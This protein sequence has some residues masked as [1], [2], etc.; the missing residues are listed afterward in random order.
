MQA[1]TLWFILASILVIFEI[2]TGTFYLLIFGAAA[3]AAAF[4]AFYGYT[5][6]IQLI[7]AAV[8][9]VAGVQ[10]LRSHP[11]T[12]SP[13]TDDLDISQPVEI[14]AW[15]KDGTARVRYRGTEW[16]ARLAEGVTGQPSQ[17]V[18]HAMQGNTL[19]LSPAK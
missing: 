17:C 6:S 8:F 14:I 15:G 9:S 2:F 11:A 12:Q 3:G 18:I 1:S 19:I 10:W 7:V 13:D 16:D 4:A 5:L